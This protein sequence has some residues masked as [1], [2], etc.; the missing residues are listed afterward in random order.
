M[1]FDKENRIFPCEYEKIKQICFMT[2]NIMNKVSFYRY[3]I[4][5]FV[6]KQWLNYGKKRFKQNKNGSGRKASY[7]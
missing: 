4:C 2:Y 5:I 6:H 3:I 7:Q 1:T